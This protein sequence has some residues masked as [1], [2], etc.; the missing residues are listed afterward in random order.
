MPSFSGW[1]VCC[2]EYIQRKVFFGIMERKNFQIRAKIKFLVKLDWQ[3]TYIIG[4]LQSVY[5]EHAPKRSCIYKW[6]NS[7][8]DSREDMQLTVSL[9]ISSR[10]LINF[11]LRA[12]SLECDWEQAFCS[13][14]DHIPKSI[15]LRSGKMEARAPL[16]RRTWNRRKKSMVKLSVPPVIK[17]YLVSAVLSAKR[18][19]ILNK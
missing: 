19:Y 5:V 14:I 17:S 3:G 4:G 7:F 15:G 2:Q 9:S 18:V 1:T 6:N 16:T 12:S 13:K 8:R 10:D 11:R